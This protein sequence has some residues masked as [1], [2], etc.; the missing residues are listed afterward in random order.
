MSTDTIYEAE[1]FH[2]YSSVVQLLAH[3]K[4]DV[5]WLHDL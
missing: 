2:H 4:V 5:L 3:M 1:V